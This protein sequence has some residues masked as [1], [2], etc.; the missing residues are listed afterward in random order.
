MEFNNLMTVGRENALL[1]M[2]SPALFVILFWTIQNDKP[3]GRSVTKG[4]LALKELTV[5]A[6]N[7]TKTEC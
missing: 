3:N 4:I 7:P 6:D 2:L 1:A 5:E